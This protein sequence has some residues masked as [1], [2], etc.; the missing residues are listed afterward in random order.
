MNSQSRPYVVACGTATSRMYVDNLVESLTDEQ[1]EKIA[2]RDANA[3]KIAV[4]ICDD[5]LGATVFGAARATLIIAAL[6]AQ[7]GNT[8]GWHALPVARITDEGHIKDTI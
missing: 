2:R 6:K 8:F 1:L 5:A 7:Y 4:N 3:P